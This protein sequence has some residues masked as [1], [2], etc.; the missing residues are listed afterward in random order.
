MEAH[1]FHRKTADDIL[2][3]SLIELSGLRE[4]TMERMRNTYKIEP[5]LL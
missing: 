4:G 3:I 2:A 5:L 1:V